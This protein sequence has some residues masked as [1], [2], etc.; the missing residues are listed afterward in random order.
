MKEN[1][2]FWGS[3]VH[4]ET[5]AVA[6]ADGEVCGLGVIANRAESVRKLVRRLGPAEQLRAGYE[7]GPTGYV[8]LNPPVRLERCFQASVLNCRGETEWWIWSA[9]WT[10]QRP[11]PRLAPDPPSAPSSRH[12]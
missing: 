6:E 8:L 2:R 4:A 10:T 1:V 7:A 9:G 5:I 12:S 11:E 3:D